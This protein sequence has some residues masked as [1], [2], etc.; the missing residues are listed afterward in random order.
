MEQCKANCNNKERSRCSNKAQSNGY[1]KIPAHQ[2]LA[3]V[4][5]LH[6]MTVSS[7][8]SS[9]SSSSSST[10]SS[11]STMNIHSAVDPLTQMLKSL[12]LQSS[13]GNTPTKIPHTVPK[14]ILLSPSTGITPLPLPPTPIIMKSILPSNVSPVLPSSSISSSSP[15]L[16]CKAVS[17]TGKHCRQLA[18]SNGYCKKVTHQKLATV[19]PPIPPTI[20]TTTTKSA[21]IIPPSHPIIQPPILPSPVKLSPT[22][23]VYVR[24]S[25][26]NHPVLSSQS[27]STV[28]SLSIPI[29]ASHFYF[30]IIPW[31]D[32]H[33]TI[34]IIP[35]PPPPL[36]SSSTATTSNTVSSTSSIVLRTN[37]SSS[38]TS[39]SS[40]S[41][42]TSSGSSP[43]VS[44]DDIGKRTIVSS[45]TYGPLYSG[46]H[47]YMDIVCKTVE[48]GIQNT[49]TV[50]I[51]S[52]PPF[53]PGTVISLVLEVA[54]IQR[55]PL[56][57][58]LLPVYG[59]LVK[60]GIRPKYGILMP[61]VYT[62]LYAVLQTL[63]KPRI[64]KLKNCSLPWRIHCLYEIAISLATLHGQGFTHDNLR[65]SN[66]LI[67]A[68]SKGGHVQLSDYGFTSIYA[69]YRK[70]VSSTNKSSSF[71][72]S[73]SSSSGNNNS[74]TKG[75]DDGENPLQSGS[76]VKPTLSEETTEWSPSQMEPP[77]DLIAEILSG[78]DNSIITLYHTKN[79]TLSVINTVLEQRQRKQLRYL[80]PEQLKKILRN[81]NKSKQSKT[82]LSQV[83][84]L[85]TYHRKFATDIYAF[86]IIAYQVLTMNAF[87]LPEYS[88]DV[89]FINAV[90]SGARPDLSILQNIPE[91]PPTLLRIIEGCWDTNASL[92]P[93]SGMELV[94]LLMRSVPSIHDN[95][96]LPVILSKPQY[97]QEAMYNY[98]S[99]VNA[100]P[101]GSKVSKI[102]FSDGLST[103]SIGTSSSSSS[104][105][106]STNISTILSKPKVSGISTTTTTTTTTTTSAATVSSGWIPKITLNECTICANDEN[107]IGVALN[108]RYQHCI[109]IECCLRHIRLELVPGAK[110]IR[111]PCCL[112]LRP[113]PQTNPIHDSCVQEVLAWSKLKNR[114]FTDPSL[115][116]LSTDEMQRYGVIKQQQDQ[117]ELLQVGCCKNCPTCGMMI[118]RPRGHAC[119]HIRP[120]TGCPGCGKHFCY[121]CLYIFKE[122]DN[123]NRCPSGCR[124]FCTP[125]CACKDCPECKPGKPCDDCDGD[126]TCW[127]CFPNARPRN[128][129][130]P[131]I[132]KYD[133]ITAPVNSTSS[134]SSSTGN[135]TNTMTNR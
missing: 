121:N 4:Y 83:I 125:S 46:K 69:E 21:T 113:Q 48:L 90:I 40:T 51:S 29:I 104:S 28:S 135:I 118:S 39:T 102:V 89:S 56:H 35:S 97:L 100:L 11:P 123:K 119:H 60:E 110:L 84:G 86:G 76:N 18:L 15:P 66:I 127:V 9:F 43:I 49:N 72:S 33:L 5:A 73:S 44:T 30:P 126:E 17:E 116:P 7:P 58:R 20:T 67:T 75:N 52:P 79:I 25:P 109:C 92:R 85:G 133:G 111:C 47:K 108:C 120:G 81:I 50:M 14:G 70:R 42:S 80:P 107:V 105:S 101:T 26:P 74:N 88:D 131:V 45:G 53:S 106:S 99:S 77:L 117:Q 2:V 82:F 68:P 57:E 124:L 63:Q 78:T 22:V 62:S 93:K 91:I 122:G 130:T 134:S 129:V 114:Q 132:T 37:S 112:A 19:V 96:P 31:S 27:L 94:D 10:V 1:C 128:W 12:Q 8:S 115:R 24:P 64:D 3:N 65:P 54:A 87:V 103:L 41:S 36:P 16:Q 98:A 38:T 6:G 71:S 59:L 23:P 55:V 34:V 61:H 13:P 32:I 95:V